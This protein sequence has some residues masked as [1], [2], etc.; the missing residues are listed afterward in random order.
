MKFPVRVESAALSSPHGSRGRR[1]SLVLVGFPSA[2]RPRRCPTTQRA[3]QRSKILPVD[4]VHSWRVTRIHILGTDHK[5]NGEMG[6]GKMSSMPVNS[7]E[8]GKCPP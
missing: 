4:S 8:G 2:A 3:H 5:T 7:E 1:R 6:K